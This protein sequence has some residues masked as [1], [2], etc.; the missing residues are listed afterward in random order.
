MRGL[1]LCGV[2]LAA[3]VTSMPAAAQAYDERPAAVVPATTGWD[4]ERRTAEI[5]MRDGVT[6]HTVILVP[7]GATASAP[8]QP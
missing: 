7:K 6:L 2:A 8:A 5:P 4:Y 1:L 3:A